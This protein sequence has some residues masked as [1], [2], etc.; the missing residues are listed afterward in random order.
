MTLRVVTPTT[1][2]PLLSIEELRAACRLSGIETYDTELA[3]HL[4]AAVELLEA[5]TQRRFLTVALEWSV[6]SFAQAAQLPVAPVA[7][8]GLTE[9]AY[10][11]ANDEPQTLTAGADYVASPCGPTVAIRPASG[12]CWPV[13]DPDAAEPVVIRFTA[14]EAQAAVAA[15]VKTA[16]ALLVARLFANKGD[17][18]APALSP[19][20]L[21]PDVEALIGPLRW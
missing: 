12:T 4:A 14:G 19:S 3:G 20:N 6:R 18:T 5:A 17:A 13:L 15:S 1:E 8:A 16:A 9:V 2:A 21:P 7:L 11:D 10:V